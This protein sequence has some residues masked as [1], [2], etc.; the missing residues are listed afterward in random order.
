M[1]V[2]AHSASCGVYLLYTAIDYVPKAT[3]KNSI[4]INNFLGEVS[5]RTDT[6]IFLQ[7]YRP[8]AVAAAFQFPQISING[9]PVWNGTMQPANVGLEGNL[10]IETVLGSSW[11]T[12]VTVW[13]TGGSPR[14]NPDENTP[15]DT[16]EPYLAWAKYAVAQTSL[17]GVITTSYGDDEQ[18]VP[19]SF[20][21]AVCSLF[22]QIGARGTTLLVSSGDDGV[23]TN[24]TCLS[25]DGKN[26]TM[27][28]PNFPASCPY[29]TT[30]GGTKNFPE[31]VAFDPR[32]GY[33]SGGG[34][35][36]YFERPSYQDVF[37]PNYIAS[38]NG[39]FNG[40][41]N[42][43]GRGYPDIAAQGY[44]FITI[45]NGSITPLDG[46]SC[47]SPTAASVLGLVNDAL[48]AA[49]KPKLGF[50]NPWLYKTGY[51]T[52]TDVVS[53]SAIGCNETGSPFGFPAK[54][55]WDAVTGFV[56]R[57]SPLFQFCHRLMIRCRAHRISSSCLRHERANG[58]HG[59]NKRLSSNGSE[60]SQIYG[61]IYTRTPTI[62]TRL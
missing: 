33:A 50:L 24:G 13:S 6:T 35:S 52:F 12:P 21:K 53:G 7:K 18:T 61:Y 40:L 3:D 54:V 38:L 28:I 2:S 42:N 43:N 27:F 37:V 36:N 47:A 45:Y 31:I 49:G 41:Y 58:G 30:V 20:A 57:L 22:A 39:S 51:K 29:V 46:T 9:G 44:H 34:F 55:G 16:N 26:T 56:S 59:L 23:G 62:S 48:I 19:E 60:I 4:G 32:N 17:P 8:E 15:T 10:D 5:N 11:P 14:F 1:T 25:N